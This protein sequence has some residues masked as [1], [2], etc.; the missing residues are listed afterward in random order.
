[1]MGRMLRILTAGE[2]HGPGLAVIL[3]GLPA[4]VPVSSASIAGELARR[5][6]GYGRGGRQRFEADAFEIQAGVR[7]GR[8]IGSPVAITIPNVEFET[9]YRELM[10]PEGEMDPS[11][12]LTRP[13][14]GHADLVG[15]L[16]YGFD[17]VRNVLE[18]ASARETA[19]R[20]AAG[21]LCKSF[22][23]ELGVARVLPRRADRE[24][25]RAALRAAHAR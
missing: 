20:V 13:R 10:G 2:S 5:R 9:T 1:M 14:P 17:D 7:H 15:T 25:A 18:R 21:V 12:R 8:T 11:K 3:E 23:A 16:K 22:L 6:H 24:G 19:A 4:G